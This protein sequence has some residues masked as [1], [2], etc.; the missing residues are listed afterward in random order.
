MTLTKYTF[1][2]IITNNFLWRI[3]LFNRGFIDI[4]GCSWSSIHIHVEFMFNRRRPRC[5]RVIAYGRWMC[6]CVS[7]WVGVRRVIL[8]YYKVFSWEN[9]LNLLTNYFFTRTSCK[10]CFIDLIAFQWLYNHFTCAKHF[11]FIFPGYVTIYIVVLQKMSFA[12]ISFQSQNLLFLYIHY[13]YTTVVNP[14]WI[15]INTNN[16]QW[17]A[18]ITR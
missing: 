15:I 10:K 13:G 12:S 18:H 1:I 4:L 14:S 3:L 6:G 16:K 7:G 8:S 17:Y 2:L 5:C 11:S 9:W